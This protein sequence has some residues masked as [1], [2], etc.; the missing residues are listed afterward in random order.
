MLGV[1]QL[2]NEGHVQLTPQNVEFALNEIFNGE[3][4]GIIAADVNKKPA[5]IFEEN[6]GGG[7]VN[8]KIYASYARGASRLNNGGGGTIFGNI[9]RLGC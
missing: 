4:D 2:E 8:G 1:C 3:S 7:V 5:L 9:R 6:G